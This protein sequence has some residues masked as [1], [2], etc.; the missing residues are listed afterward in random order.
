MTKEDDATDVKPGLKDGIFYTGDKGPKFGVRYL[1]IFLLALCNGVAYAT[2]GA[3]SVALVAM[4]DNSTSPNPDVP[5]Y[6]WKNTNVIISS[7]LWSS[8]PFTFVA[9]YLGKQYGPKWILVGGT[10]INN[11]SFLF[12]PAVANSFGATGVIVCRVIQGVALSF[13]NLQSSVVMGRWAPPE[14]RSRMGY[15]VGG[16]VTLTALSSSLANG[17]LAE[18]TWGWPSIFYIIGSIGITVAAVIALFGSQSA[19]TDPRITRKEQLYLETTLFNA[20]IEHKTPWMKI[21]TSIHCWAIIIGVSG[22]S[23]FVTLLSTEFSVFLAKVFEFDLS[24]TGTIAA[25][26]TLIGA[27]VGFPLSYLSDYLPK[28]GLISVVNSRRLFQLVGVTGVSIGMV[29]MTF[30]PIEHRRWTVGIISIAEPFIMMTGIGGAGVNILDISP[31]YA[32]IISGIEST[33]SNT[34]VIFAPLV[35]DWVCGEHMNDISRWRI[36][37]LIAS[38]FAIGSAIFFVLFATDQ[39]QNWD[40][41]SDE[42]VWKEEKES[43]AIG[44]EKSLEV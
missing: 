34:V 10:I 11:V 22:Y 29:S 43:S 39:K 19:Q 36:V 17:F 2:K 26:P 5:T 16:I 1:Q 30:V 27:A 21:F 9:G 6:D 8:I 37:F 41:E 31:K 4:T 35:V 33:F 12:I 20:N 14:E 7:I 18:T 13:V 40:D 3:F 44:A 28:K 24:T 38:A 15:I 25:M 32:G 23:W 42:E